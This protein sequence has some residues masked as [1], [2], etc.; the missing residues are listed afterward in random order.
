VLA[1]AFD[2]QRAREE[3]RCN[4]SGEAESLPYSHTRRRQ[5]RR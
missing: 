5:G 2:A 4:R 3:V 1:A